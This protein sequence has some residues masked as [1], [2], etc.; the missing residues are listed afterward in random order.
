[1]AI[2][3]IGDI[4][5]CFVELQQLLEKINFD[6]SN[7][8]LWFTGDLVNRGPQSLETLRFIKKLGNSAKAVLG[9]HDLHL[10]SVACNASKTKRKDTFDA[11]LSAPDR[12]ELIS[13]L[14]HLPLMHHEGEFYM[15]HAGLPPQWTLETAM[16]L[17]G[18]LE[19][20]LRSDESSVFF[21]HM[22]GDEPSIW[23]DD[24]NSY[25]RLRFIASAFTRLRYCDLYGRFDF[26]EKCAPGKQASY[27]FPWFDV[28]GRRSE[29]AN[30]FFGHW[31]TLG[32]YVKNN[33]YCLDTGC[34]W[35]GELT[36]LKIDG[37]ERLRISLNCNKAY[38]APGL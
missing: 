3:V 35:G 36:A 8:S 37:D 10:L 1:M 34:L 12:E 28:P 5:G 24:L 11:I 38:Q 18:E 23:S 31:S 2:Y 22:Y 19:S 21:K 9:N 27:L 33:C 4:Q 6:A 16:A 29:G 26:K 13:W 7:D 32:F 20:V 30:I 15:I 14:S 25:D 17:A